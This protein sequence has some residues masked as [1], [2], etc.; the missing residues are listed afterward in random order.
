MFYR[1]I[2]QGFTTTLHRLLFQEKLS[3]CIW[4]WILLPF[5]ILFFIAVSPTA[6]AIYTLGDLFT[7]TSFPADATHVPTLYFPK[8][9]SMKLEAAVLVILGIV[10]GGI[11]CAGWDLSFPTHTQQLLWR[12]SS[13]FLTVFP[14]FPNI[15]LFSPSSALYIMA[16]GFTIVEYLLLIFGP[17]H[18]LL[19]DSNK[20]SGSTNFR[21]SLLNRWHGLMTKLG[22]K[23]YNHDLPMAWQVF[24]IAVTFFIV[25]CWVVY[26]GA[27]SIILGLA[28]ILLRDQ[29]PR[30]Y[31]S[32]DWTKYYP[33]MF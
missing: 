13:L 8:T 5:T 4:T 23:K 30:A 15:F 31:L 24:L 18:P 28:L 7:T 33:H 25:L 22:P 11:H 29:P 9:D 27:R 12:S 16:S 1:M 14:I 19:L 2:K 3:V 10:F 21:A 32:V 6:V 26:L 17:A 20:R